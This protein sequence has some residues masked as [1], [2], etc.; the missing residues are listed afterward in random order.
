MRSLDAVLPLTL[1]DAPR[2]RILLRSLERFC[3]VLGRLFLVTRAGDVASIERSLG[4]EFLPGKLEVLS[5]D[6]LVP[7]LSAHRARGWYR[8]QLIKLAIAERVE[9]DYYLTLDADVVATRPITL[10]RLLPSGRA[11]CTL[12]PGE[13]RDWYAATEKLLGTRGAH[14]GKLHSVTPA[15]LAR[16]GVR[17]LTESL[18]RRFR[19]RRFS[20]GMRGLRQRWLALRA[21]GRGEPWRLFLLG[22]L[23]WTEY[24]LYYTFLEASGEFERFHVLSDVP[25]YD[26]RHSVWY[27]D[28]EQFPSWDPAPLFAGEGPP[29]FVVIQSNTGLDPALV[30][31]R[32]RPFLEEPARAA[33]AA[34]G[35]R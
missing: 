24:A 20:P 25:I 23:P 26:V 28:R 10:E 3:P 8:Q 29:F 2:A 21:R 4:A 5:E 22:G 14:P 32:L 7:E 11:P 15:L 16:E 12:L 6:A 31:E 34:P 19:E 18:D 9:S 17:A 30:S 1:R 13:H 33:H 27:R 35:S